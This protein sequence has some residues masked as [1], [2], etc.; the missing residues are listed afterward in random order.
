VFAAIVATTF[1]A[2]ASSGHQ[3]VPQ[4]PAFRSQTDLVALAV[5]VVDARGSP[6][7]GLARSVFT[8]M[9]DGHPQTIQYFAGDQVPI[10]LVV[11]L[12]ASESMKGAR[13]AVA[14]E[15]VKGFLDRLGPE[16]EFTLLGFNDRPFSISPWSTN[17]DTIL[18]ALGRVEPQG[19]TALFHTVSTAIDALRGSRNRRQALVIV[20]DGNDQLR[21]ERPT[22]TLSPAS[23]QRLAAAIDLV[24]RSEVVVY[25]IGVDTP[26]AQ[27]LNG[28]ALRS[29]TNPT[30][31]STRVVDSDAA[32]LRAAD[33]IG[34]ELRFQYLLGFTPAHPDDGRFHS[35]R[36][37]V[38]GC[39]G[40][41]VRARRGYV[42]A[43]STSRS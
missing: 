10:S 2:D 43:R 33:R 5:T 36:V 28:E 31:G 1:L 42:A 12:D 32:I 4:P 30:G 38:D 14:S 34:E 39:H 37:T 18:G 23:R 3:P 8:V 11:A 22:A 35:V 13:F 26:F 25:A 24:Q 17:R 7:G 9:E 15:S 16:D 41:A 19:N 21:G 27:P 20:S 6:V 40:C 29:I